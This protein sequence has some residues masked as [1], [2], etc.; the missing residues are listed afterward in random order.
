[1]IFPIKEPCPN[2]RRLSVCKQTLFIDI[3]STTD[4]AVIELSGLLWYVKKRKPMQNRKGLITLELTTKINNGITKKYQ[5]KIY[6]RIF[7]L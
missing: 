4:M 1:M 5:L 6:I 3:Y 2:L 7:F